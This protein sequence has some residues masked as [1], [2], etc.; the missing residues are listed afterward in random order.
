[1]PGVAITLPELGTPE[2]TVS[3]WY[4]GVGEQV[5]EGDRVI[6]VLI[7]G[8]TVDV[9]APVTGFVRDRHVQ[10]GD[11]VNVGQVLGIIDPDELV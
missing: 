10:P 5:F 3:L 6:E 9:P 8:A 4:V 1:M 7:R 2:A 11:L